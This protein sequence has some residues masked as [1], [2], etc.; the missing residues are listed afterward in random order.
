MFSISSET[1]ENAI[2]K[3]KEV[4]TTNGVETLPSDEVLKEAF[5]AAVQVVA[6]SFGM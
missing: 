5:E 3:M 6:R 1:K 2:E 4:L